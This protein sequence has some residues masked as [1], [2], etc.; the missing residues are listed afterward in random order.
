M[1]KMRALWLRFCAIFATQRIGNDFDA[2]LEGNLNEQI[3]EGV[4][5]GLSEMEARR[6]ALLR[7]GGVDQVRQAYR[8]RAT[9]PWAESI[10]RDM[11]YA[12][13]GFGRSPVFALTAILTLALG[14][15]A[16]TAV[17][18]VVDRILFRALPYA[19][20]N[21]L[22]SVGLTAPIIPQEFMLGG[23]YYQWQDN[24]TPF[25]AL[26]SE[27]GVNECDLTEHNPQRLNCANVEQNFLPTLGISP[28][29][30]RNFLPEEDRPNG[31][32]VALI[33]YG[34]WNSQYGRDPNIVNR[35]ITIDLHQVRVVGVLPKTFEMPT[36]QK[37]DIL[38]P[39][40]LDP[41]AERKADP[42]H[43]LYAFARLK[44]GVSIAQA[45]AQLKPVFDY[46]LNLAPARFRS[47]VHFR[48]RSLRDFQMQDVNLIAWIL[49]GTVAAVLLIACGNVAGLLLARAAARERELAVRSALG[50]T[51]GRLVR[52]AL[53]ESTLLSFCG[54]VAGCALAAGLLRVFVSIAPTSLP[55]LAKAHLDLRI[56]VFVVL[57]SLT[58][59][60]LFG[61]IPAMFRPRPIALATRI[62]AAPSR[63]LLRRVMVVMQIAASMILLVSAALLV[64]SFANLQHEALGMETHGVLTAGISL[65]REKYAT[66][67]SVMNY[68]AQA[69]EALR[70]LPGVSLVALSDSIPPSGYHQD[71]IYSLITVDGRPAPTGATG[72]M[73]TWRWVTPEYFNALDVPIVRGAGFDRGEQESTDHWLIVSR[74]LAARLFP[75]EN[76]VGQRVKP[77][78]NDSW[79]TIAGVAAD[80]KNAGLD[81][82]E[83]PE[84]YRLRRN[85]AEDWQQA[86]SAVLILKTS[87][88]PKALAPWVRSQLAEIDGT[89]PAQIE[90]MNER[91]SGLE[92]RPR[93]EAALL[94]FFAFTGLAMAIIGLYGVVAFM[95]AQR[96]QEIGIRM[97]L[98][99]TRADVMRLILREGFRLIAIGGA[100]GLAVA[101]AL[102]RL[103]QTVLFGV[104]PHD[105]ASFGTVMVLLTM[106]AL[107]AIL[108]P[109]RAAM[110]TDPMTA[111]RCE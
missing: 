89:V 23:S 71:H 66:P 74:D 41:A 87:T 37:A 16:T 19:D 78:P 50:A 67:Q 108:I 42:G 106:V 98:G 39:E 60:I 100:I 47:E 15:G 73:V 53:T 9:L 25:T 70:R 103:L 105:P 36:L 80:V 14:I 40:A 20:D 10:L 43:V 18:S 8:D 92:D 21:R 76:P 96:T 61:S 28:I 104:S 110:K 34:L 85:V 101:F 33:S 102:S 93:F 56:A 64:R 58:A 32:K 17:F 90:T 38:E 45:I 29:A 13:R 22:V 1:R 62:S 27:S 57:L 75:G 3:A 91:V 99:A 2:E 72:G 88:A 48:V 7:I 86:P 83:Q 63:T 55:F 68:F 59:G 31:P 12:L 49:L 6:Q 95:A 111:L 69:Q 44:P 46:S 77:T 51:R 4:R 24:Q 81:G 26:T 94:T 109:A 5:S 65:N 30:G 11:R 54:A 35:L 52:Q 82:Q 79:Y 84:Y 107:V 97:A